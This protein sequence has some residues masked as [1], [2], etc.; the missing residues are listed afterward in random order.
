MCYLLQHHQWGQAASVEAMWDLQ[1]PLPQLLPVQ[2]VQDKQL[3]R[4][5][6]LQEPF[7][8]WLAARE[9]CVQIELTAGHGEYHGISS[10]VR[11]HVHHN[12]DVAVEC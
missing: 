12:Q 2:V 10:S 3:Q 8:L 4:L 7:Q 6:T 5:S 9:G 1:E 11:V